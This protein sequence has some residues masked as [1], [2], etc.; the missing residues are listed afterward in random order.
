MSADQPTLGK[1]LR[2]LRAGNGWTL[3]QMSESSGIPVSTL[4]KVEHDRL[5]LTYDKLLQISQ[6]LGIQVSELFASPSAESPR[7][8]VMARR[9]IGRRADAL[10]VTTPNYDYFYFSPEL[11][12]KR[13]IPILT[14]IRAKSLEEFG[15]LVHHS[16]EEFIYVLDG[17]MEVHTEFYDPV[18]LEVGQSIYID[19]KMGHAYLAGPDCDEATALAVC[20]SSEEDLVGSLMTLHDNASRDQAIVARTPAPA[21]PRASRRKRTGG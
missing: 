9:S 11:R 4:S 13:M 15:A 8:G 5:T 21:R 2:E 7:D 19:S 14:H 10:R 20:S 16:G 6:R 18:L 3:K 12:K 1:A 17:Q